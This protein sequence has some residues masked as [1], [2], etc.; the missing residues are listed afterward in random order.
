[1]EYYPDIFY[2]TARLS[3]GDC[4]KLFKEAHEL[5]YFWVVD[6]HDDHGVRQPNGMTFKQILSCF[7]KSQR[8][9]LH[10]TFI[11]RR[12]YEN[13]EQYLEIG[14][15]TLGRKWTYSDTD[16]GGDLFLW[17]NVKLEHKDYLLK[18]YFNAVETL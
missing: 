8:R 1:M 17:V 11:H 6:Q 4:V 3:K 14:F 10:I 13:W 5:S 7:R 18:K 12:G 15:C 16:K 9:N 2:K